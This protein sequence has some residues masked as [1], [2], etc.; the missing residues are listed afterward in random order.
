[1]SEICVCISLQCCNVFPVAAFG[2]EPIHRKHVGSYLLLH[3]FVIV[4]LSSMS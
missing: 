1:M 3:T 2:R 4:C